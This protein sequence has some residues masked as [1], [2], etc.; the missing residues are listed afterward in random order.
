MAGYYAAPEL[1]AETIT[2]DGWVRTHDLAGST[3]AATSP[4]STA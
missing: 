3:S 2:T 4:W 1:T